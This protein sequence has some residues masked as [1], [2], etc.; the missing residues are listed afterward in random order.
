[1]KYVL[2]LLL[3]FTNTTFARD[4][5]ERLTKE[6]APL[7]ETPGIKS[8]AAGGI[9]FID[10]ETDDLAVVNKL[11]EIAF[12]LNGK[13]RS[14]VRLSAKGKDLI[15]TQI[16]KEIGSPY[17]VVRF[18]SNSLLLEGTAQS[19]FE[20]DRSVEMAKTIL[21]LGAVRTPANATVKVS[22]TPETGFTII[23]LLRV[24]KREKEPAPKK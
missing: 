12:A 6:L 16:Q 22:V 23:D 1:M 8:H 10:G 5:A 19:D 11:S 4:P 17:I 7:L 18:V 13:A 3:V 9:V 21:N 24:G 15:A 14:L 2:L 20:A